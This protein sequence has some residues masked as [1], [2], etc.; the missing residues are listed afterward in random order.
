MEKGCWFLHLMKT[1][2]E[3]DALLFVSVEHAYYHPS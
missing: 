1:T 2:R 3:N